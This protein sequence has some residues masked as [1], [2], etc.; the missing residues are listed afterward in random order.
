MNSSSLKITDE[1]LAAK[2]FLYGVFV[3]LDINVDT[4]KILSILMAIDTILGV[5]KVIRLGNKFSFKKLIWGM[6]TKVSV[7]IV[8]MV[9]ALTAKALN[10][11]FTWFVSA[12][13]NIL[14]LAEA[15]SS[16][17]NIISIKEA[18]ELE[19]TDFI[20][21]LLHKVRQ[22]LST[23]INQLFGTITQ[24][25]NEKNENNDFSDNSSK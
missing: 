22:G 16:I 12:V 6:I 13:L 17:T 25:N 11:D 14:V 10:F 7:L 21:R 8:P 3:F 15:F 1:V 4:V 23:L 18:K 2:T 20:T 19:N 5:F 9:L 24:D